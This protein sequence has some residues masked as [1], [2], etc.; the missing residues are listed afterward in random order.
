MRF[1]AL[2][3][4]VFV[5]L[6]GVM[7]SFSSIAAEKGASYRLGPNDKVRVTVFGEPDLSGEFEISGTGVLA[8]PLVGQVPVGGATISEAEERLGERLQ[9][10]FL[11][12]PKVSIEVMNYRPF[13][14]LGEVNNPGS[15]SYVNG[16]S[17]LN[18]VALGGGFT[19]RADK[20]D[21]KL[22]REAEGKKTE[23]KAHPDTIVQPGDVIEV[24]ERFF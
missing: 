4:W 18:A 11:R 9:E 7:L 3:R 20:S 16:M 10:G 14:I 12:N 17:V 6:F 1:A 23:I 13:Y 8:L 2:T 24:G 15:Y 5:L 21:I 22:R 19:Y